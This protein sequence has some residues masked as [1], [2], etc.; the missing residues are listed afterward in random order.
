M[1]GWFISSLAKL[2]A[3]TMRWR[4]EGRRGLLTDATPHPIMI[5]FWH[6]RIFLMP[7][8]YRRN[9]P[10]R[11]VSAIVSA[12]KDGAVLAAVLARCNVG[13]VRGSSSRRGPQAL[14]EAAR[15]MLRDQQDIAITPDGPRG[16]KYH[17]APGVISLAQ[18]TQQPIVPVSYVLSHKITLNSWDN[19]TIPVPFT[20]C[21]VCYG[22]PIRVPRDADES[23]REN[24]RLELERVL[25]TLS[26]ELPKEEQAP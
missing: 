10:T 20:Q 8:V 4:E 7:Y 2:I 1:I 15:L 26:D 16:P 3:R 19:F 24:K 9:C 14:R 5:L 22:E 11:R 23:L 21:R 18:L 13:A 17:V 12:S 6:N 25:L